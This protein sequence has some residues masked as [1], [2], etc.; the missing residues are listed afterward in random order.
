MCQGNFGIY[1]IVAV[2]S[3]MNKMREI[4][5]HAGKV[6][7]EQKSQLLGFSNKVLWF[8]GL[9]G[10]GKSTLSREIEKKLHENGIISYCLDGDNIRHGL[11]SN[12]GFSEEDR[13][14]N[15]RRIME[16]AKLF[17]DSGIFVLIS[18]ISPYRDIRDQARN[19]I[20]KDFVEIFVN[21]PLEECERRDVKGMYRKARRGEIKEFTGISAPYET[22][23]KPEI[24]VNTHQENIEDS[25]NRIMRYLNNQ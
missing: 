19:L 11:N 12:L 3:F 6:T 23:E 18:F 5:W 22:P 14:E 7:K 15:I 16:V 13:K 10:S 17:Y 8:T 1:R 21:C 24:T 9:S 25:V 4:I 2:E 20:G